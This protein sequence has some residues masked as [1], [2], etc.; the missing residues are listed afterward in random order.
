M[1]VNI[2][3]DASFKPKEMLH[4]FVDLLGIAYR[5]RIIHWYQR[6]LSKKNGFQNMASFVLRGQ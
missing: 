2:K 5:L 6:P 4:M 3:L 1:P